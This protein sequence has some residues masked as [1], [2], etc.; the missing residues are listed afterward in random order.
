MDKRKAHKRKRLHFRHGEIQPCYFNGVEGVKIHPRPDDDNRNIKLDKIMLFRYITG[1]TEEVKLYKVKD[2]Q[3]KGRYFHVTFKNGTEAMADKI[4]E[5]KILTM[6]H[7]H[8]ICRPQE[9]LD[10]DEQPNFMGTGCALTRIIPA[11]TILK[12]LRDEI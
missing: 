5:Y 10:F 6:F 1:D 2:I 7:R 3:P 12:F 11:G 9:R 8:Y 4:G